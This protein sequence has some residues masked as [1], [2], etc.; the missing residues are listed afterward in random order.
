M[1]SPSNHMDSAT[2]YKTVREVSALY[3]SAVL[4]L[5]DTTPSPAPRRLPHVEALEHTHSTRQPLWIEIISDPESCIRKVL[6]A[7]TDQMLMFG[8][9]LNSY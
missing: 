2:Q 7:R 4:R 3:F 9:A 5:P 8:Q 6:S 1:W